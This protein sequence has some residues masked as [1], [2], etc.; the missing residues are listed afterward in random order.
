MFALPSA[1]LQR[2]IATAGASASVSL[3]GT[4]R[5]LKAKLGSL[6]AQVVA[7]QS[8]IQ[9]PRTAS[10]GAFSDSVSVSSAAATPSTASAATGSGV[11][12]GAAGG[13]AGAV[14][15]RQLRQQWFAAA[16]ATPSSIESDEVRANPGVVSQ[17]GPDATQASRAGRQSFGAEKSKGRDSASASGG[18]FRFGA[19]KPK[20]VSTPDRGVAL[21]TTG[22]ASSPF[23]PAFAAGE[24]LPR[25]KALDYEAASRL[26]AR[27]QDAGR[28]VQ[29]Q[30]AMIADLTEKLRSQWRVA[31]LHLRRSSC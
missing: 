14:S 27:L 11:L 22:S 9:R 31:L 20:P 30:A 7:Q 26:L 10:E 8:N 25:G 16:S 1:L 28:Q 21:P 2:I 23:S 5:A 4:S 29:H 15:Q 19:S 24:G 6:V 17:A 12:S 13:G 3:A 18:L